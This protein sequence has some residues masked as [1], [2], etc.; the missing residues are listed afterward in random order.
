MHNNFRA[1]WSHC[2]KMVRSQVTLHVSTTNRHG[3]S[4]RLPSSVV[5]RHP[6]ECQCVCK[7]SVDLPFRNFVLD[8][9][10]LVC[11]DDIRPCPLDNFQCLATL[12]GPKFQRRSVN[13]MP[14]QVLNNNSTV[15]SV[16]QIMNAEPSSAPSNNSQQHLMNDE[17]TRSAPVTG[18]QK[19]TVVIL[20]FVNLINYM[21]RYT[22]AGK[23]IIRPAFSSLWMHNIM[24]CPSGYRCNYVY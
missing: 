5:N 16:L 19:I 24:P 20:C 12:I 17:A 23:T 2:N 22:I 13:V 7:T 21:D 4:N 18:K 9:Y 15:K 14:T 1:R 6:S 11:C 8:R 10:R 3:L